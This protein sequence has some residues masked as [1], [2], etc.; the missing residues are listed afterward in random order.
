MPSRE[1]KGPNEQLGL[2]L[3]KPLGWDEMRVVLGS[4]RLTT[5]EKLVL[6]RIWTFDGRRFGRQRACF[7]SVGFLAEECGIPTKTLKNVMTELS[8]LGLIRSRPHGRGRL[9]TITI[10]DDAFPRST[11]ADDLMRARQI[12]DTVVQSGRNDL[13][14]QSRKKKRHV[15]PAGPDRSHTRDPVISVELE[16][17]DPPSPLPERGVSNRGGEPRTL[18]DIYRGMGS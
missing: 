3:P 12:F 15:P 8:W 16:G 18:G 1:T 7:A 5:T 6:L 11:D 10:P 14:K 4:R 17:R 13:A 9:R 2:D